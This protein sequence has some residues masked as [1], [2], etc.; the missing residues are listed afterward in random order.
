MVGDALSKAIVKICEVNN[1][2]TLYP[3]TKVFKSPL[4]MGNDD[5]DTS[6]SDSSS[7][8]GLKKS[9]SLIELTKEFNIGFKLPDK[10]FVDPNTF[11]IQE[12]YFRDIAEL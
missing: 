7:K 1:I 3:E 12:K 8:P 6:A 10:S 2:K 9:A 11:V 5:H 4:L